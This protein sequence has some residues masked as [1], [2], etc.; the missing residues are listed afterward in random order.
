MFCHC[1]R[2]VVLGVGPQSAVHCPPYYPYL[3][4]FMKRCIL[5]VLGGLLFL[6]AR[7]QESADSVPQYW[8]AGGNFNSTFQQVSSANWVGG[9]QNSLS[10]GAVASLFA[11]YDDTVRRRW[12]NNL[13]L[14]YGLG[15]IGGSENSF[16]KTNDNLLLV[17]RYGRKLATRFYLSAL[18]DFRSQLT[19][20]FRY[21][22]VNDSVR[23]ATQTSE[24]LAP[25]FLITSLGVTYS[26]TRKK[27]LL[28]RRADGQEDDD[29][30]D[31]DAKDRKNRAR[32]YFS[33][34]L[35]PFS[36]KFTFVLSDELVALNLYGTEGENVR[37][38]LG[39]SLTL[40]VRKRLVENV[41]V[42]S[43]L[44]LFS[45]YQQPENVDLNFQT[46]VV[47]KV[48]RFLAANVALQ[49]IY[50][51]DINVEREDGSS[52]PALQLQNAVN[53]GLSYGF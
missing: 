44:N 28:K 26:P 29:D 33:V 14:G 4:N 19:P 15:R 36:G 45:A 7:A 22:Q 17:S 50:D 25:G 16:I 11:V 30:D 20:G 34:T 9:G 42:S 24:F 5:T 6:A 10:L 12:E 39:S 43:N 23:N 13:E 31:D 27:V 40:V 21:E 53:V 37:A 52:G 38:E 49:F 35:S 48:N 18:L 41:T 1:S 51:D 2:P 8:N 32:D 46:V 47:L 3:L